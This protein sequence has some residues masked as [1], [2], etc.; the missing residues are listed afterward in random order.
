VWVGEEGKEGDEK[1]LLLNHLAYD[2]LYRT[3]HTEKGR[4]SNQHLVG[5]LAGPL[6]NHCC[7]V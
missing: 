5:Y 4:D 7:S 6:C 1:S 2:S 3:A